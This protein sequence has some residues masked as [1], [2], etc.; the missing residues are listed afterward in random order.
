MRKAATMSMRNMTR[1]IAGFLDIVG[2]A[3]AVSAAVREGRQAEDADLKRLGVDP[4]R[5]RSIKRF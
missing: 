2:S 5:F 1:G 4:Q 3:C